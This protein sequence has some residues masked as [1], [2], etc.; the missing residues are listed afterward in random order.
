MDLM[1]FG[2]IERCREEKG[3]EREI[4]EGKAPYAERAV[5]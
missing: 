5:N 3:V 4:V 2:K 1:D